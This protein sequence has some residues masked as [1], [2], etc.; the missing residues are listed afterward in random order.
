M[1]AEEISTPKV[2]DD[3]PTEVNTATKTVEAPIVDPPV[4]ADASDTPKTISDEAFSNF[5]PTEP[6]I[7]E[8]FRSIYARRLSLNSNL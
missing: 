8:Q 6:A 5:I 4:A 1:N 2:M 7:P 3:I